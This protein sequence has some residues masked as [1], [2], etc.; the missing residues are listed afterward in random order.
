VAVVVKEFPASI[1]PGD[2]MINAKKESDVAGEATPAGVGR[3]E[4]ESS[5]S[6]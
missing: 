6:G 1:A 2:D 4:E 3:R 5:G